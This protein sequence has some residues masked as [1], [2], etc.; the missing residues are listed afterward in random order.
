MKGGPANTYV[1]SLIKAENDF[2]TR[3]ARCSLTIESHSLRRG[4]V[5]TATVTPVPNT[6]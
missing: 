6:Y 5:Q 2:V 3:V 1:T 4:I